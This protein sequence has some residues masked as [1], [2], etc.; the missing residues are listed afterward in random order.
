MT[1]SL[2]VVDLGVA[3]Y[4]ETWETQQRL[5]DRRLSGAIGDVLLLCEHP[6]TYTIGKNGVD[7]VSRHLRL[8]QDELATYGI[9]VFEIDRGGDITYH[10]PGQIVGYPI[11]NLNDHYRDVHRYLRDLEEVILRT[12]GEY[13]ITAKRIPDIT[14]VWIDSPRGPE[15][16]CAIGVK[17]T[18]WITMHGF[19][20]NVNTNLDFFGGIVPCGIT[21]K[22]VTSLQ[23]LMGRE[24]A[25]GEVKERLVAHFGAVFHLTQNPVTLS[26][27]TDTMESIHG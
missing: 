25:L 17:V 2:Q 19:A 23:K 8:N 14:G 6:N 11:L 1:H 24:V 15:K 18:R 3:D 21:D 26:S 5:F 4:R 20:F 13:G 10:G 16:I 9:G 7:N 22:G 12:L 27:L